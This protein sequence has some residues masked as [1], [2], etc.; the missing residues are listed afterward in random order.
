MEKSIREFAAI[1]FTVYVAFVI[2]YAFHFYTHS[3]F[4]CEL[5]IAGDDCYWSCTEIHT[6]TTVTLGM[7]VALGLGYL[8]VRYDR[9]HSKKEK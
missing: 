4:N 9:K 6:I 7:F 3:F 1:C 8:F 5:N 2:A